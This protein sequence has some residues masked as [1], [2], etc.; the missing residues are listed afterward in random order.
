MIKNLIIINFENLINYIQF[1]DIV[2]M[3]LTV[4]TC[5]E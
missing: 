3:G 1:I 5:V 2:E 4:I